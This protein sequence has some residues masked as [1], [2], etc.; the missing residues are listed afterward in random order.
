MQT[1]IENLP[2]EVGK[3]PTHIYMLNTDG[4]APSNPGKIGG[5]G[6]LRDHQGKIIY[7]FSIPLG[8]GTNN[9]AE[10]QAALHGLQWC[11]QYGFLKVIL[12]CQHVYR[13]A[14][15]TADCLAK[16]S[17]KFDIVQHYYTK[18]QLPNLAK[19][20]YQLEEMEMTQ[21]RRKK[22]KRIKNPP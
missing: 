14:N 7:A 20:S 3:P 10:S 17:H 5:G 15:S 8:T 13:E 1:R 6:I 9:Q 21:F 22:L 16:W 19:G 4:S 11:V 18:Q 12:E 2:S